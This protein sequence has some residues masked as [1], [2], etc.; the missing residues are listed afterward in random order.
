[1]Y[2]NA[3]I[4][5]ISCFLPHFQQ[6]QEVRDVEASQEK[7]AV[8]IPETKPVPAKPV[9]LPD[10]P[11]VKPVTATPS[12]GLKPATVAKPP[13]PVAREASPGRTT[14]GREFLLSFK[15]LEV[16]KVPP[17]DLAK[18]DCYRSQ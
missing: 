8:D 9:P 1:M 6:T 4:T 16:C 15:P 12:Q 10:K 2:C 18:H 7:G 3:I 5:S 13:D 14:Y 17:P 11:V